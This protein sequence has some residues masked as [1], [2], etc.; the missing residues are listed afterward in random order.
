MSQVYVAAWDTCADGTGMALMG[1]SATGMAE[2]S[3]NTSVHTQ[4]TRLR[5]KSLPGQNL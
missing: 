4:Q 1:P 2:Q 5:G 3:Q